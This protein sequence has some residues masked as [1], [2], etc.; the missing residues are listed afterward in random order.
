MS[1]NSEL[2]SPKETD[3]WVYN[4]GDLRLASVLDQSFPV[5]LVVGSPDL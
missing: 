1:F 2:N 3:I 4:S 5:N